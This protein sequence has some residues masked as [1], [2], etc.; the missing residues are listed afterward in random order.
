MRPSPPLRIL[1]TD[2]ATRLRLGPEARPVPLL[3]SLRILAERTGPF[4]GNTDDV[5]RTV[6]YSRIV[7]FILERL[8]GDGP[9]PDLPAVSRRLAR[10]VFADDDRITQMEIDLRPADPADTT[11][12]HLQEWERD[13][14][15]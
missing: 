11:A 12:R 1:I 6:D 14:V 15:C 4:G 9:F 3:A 2:V 7:R 10:F 5:G 8:D 13:H